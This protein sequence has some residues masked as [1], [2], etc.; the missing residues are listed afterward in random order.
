VTQSDSWRREIDVIIETRL[1]AAGFERFDGISYS[2]HVND[3]VLG[4]VHITNQKLFVNPDPERAII[5]GRFGMIH[6]QL[7]QVLNQLEV[8]YPLHYW[9]LGRGLSMIG[10]LI[11]QFDLRR[12]QSLAEKEKA[13]D[14]LVH[15]LWTTRVPYVRGH[16]NSLD[17]VIEFTKKIDF[18][19]DEQMLCTAL[20]M[21]G[22]LAEAKERA[23]HINAL[24]TTSEVCKYYWPQFKTKFDAWLVQKAPVP[25]LKDARAN[26]F[27]D[28]SEQYASMLKIPPYAR[29][30]L[31]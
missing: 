1:L 4:V 27:K 12:T 9:T 18:Q 11:S 28:A 31:D 30:P 16:F 7:G 20:A 3:Q 14:D 15:L 6:F 23:D 29:P 13:I 24:P 8:Y 22:K 5:Y 25:S 17:S 21:S 2:F 26:T 19:R 10:D